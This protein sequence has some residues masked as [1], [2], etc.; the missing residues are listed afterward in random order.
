MIV[1]PFAS[2]RAGFTLVELSIVLVILGLI[3]GGIMAGQNLLRAAEMRS[4]A[5]EFSR[6]SSAINNFRS[7][8]RAIPGDMVNA[9]D[10]WGDNPATGGC[11]DA[12]VTDGTPGTCNGNGNGIIDLNAAGQTSEAFQFWNQLA[13]AGLIEGQFSGFA[14]SGGIAHTTESNAPKS[15]AQNAYWGA[16]TLSNYTGTW[17]NSYTYDYANFFFFGALQS[18][19]WPLT[20]TLT[21]KEA[22]NIDLKLDDGKP[23]R[24]M[25][26]PRYLN[27]VCSAA[28]SIT[29]YDAAYALNNTSIA[30]AIYFTRAF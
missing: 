6:Y 30:C 20:A 26:I 15:K 7:Q 16:Y 28:T 10:Y 18:N 1:R 24:G 27:N 5:T 22:W 25:I 3:V 21:P 29:D 11:A 13:L 23:G 14:G 17:P 8:Y 12:A 9:T 2:F 4:I 19:T